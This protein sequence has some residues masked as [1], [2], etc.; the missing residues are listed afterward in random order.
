MGLSASRP[1]K[2]GETSTSS[3][4]ITE[5][6]FSFTNARIK[7][8]R[9]RISKKY[10]TIIQEE[11]KQ[12]ST[13]PADLTANLKSKQQQNTTMKTKSMNELYKSLAIKETALPL[14]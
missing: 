12:D 2:I 3:L 9:P 14:T 5:Q 11:I 8:D 7:E 13:V 6:K 1:N 4:Q 10:S